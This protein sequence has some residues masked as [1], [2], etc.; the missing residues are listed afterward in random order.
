ML[1][2]KNKTTLL[3]PVVAYKLW[4]TKNLLKADGL[5]LHPEVIKL[6]E[7]LNKFINNT[8]IYQS[9]KEEQFV[10]QLLTT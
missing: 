4:V 3:I 9:K 10:R 8:N 7:E 2:H 6:F 5:Y 1:T